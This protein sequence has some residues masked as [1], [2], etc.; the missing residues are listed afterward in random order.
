M[1]IP[2]RISGWTNFVGISG[3]GWKSKPCQPAGGGFYT[4]IRDEIIFPGPPL[5]G[6]EQ[7][8]HHRLGGHYRRAISIFFQQFNLIPSIEPKTNIAFQVGLAG[9]HDPGSYAELAKHFGFEPH[10]ARYPEQLSGGQQQ[11]VAISRVMAPRTSLALAD[12]PKGNL[13]DAVGETA[14]DL[15]LELV[16]ETGT[17]LLLVTHSIRLA[18]FVSRWLRL[19]TGRV[20]SC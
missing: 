9:R 14:V 16:G 6:E 2:E 12:A 15:M 19:R 1:G 4:N 3:K 20:A 10:L 8:L 11:R 7:P 5:E 17:G 13:D 18:A